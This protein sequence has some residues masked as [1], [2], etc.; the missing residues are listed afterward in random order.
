MVVVFV[1]FEIEPFFGISL[2]KETCFL[3]NVTFASCFS[4]PWL[5]LG[6]TTVDIKKLLAGME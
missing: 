1:V 3:I 6:M 2:L 5:S 4:L